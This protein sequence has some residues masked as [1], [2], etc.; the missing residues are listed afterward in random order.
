M[1]QAKGTSIAQY[2]LTIS[3]HCVMTDP[4]HQQYR[5]SVTCHTNREPVLYCLRALCEFAEEGPYP[6]IGWGG[7]GVDEWRS[8]DNCVTFRFT[9]PDYRDEFVGTA[10]RILPTGSWTVEDHD[11]NDPAQRQRPAH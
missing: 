3:P 9:D 11:D 2:L 4:N 5:Y 10:N 7:T 1:S 6:Q 8:S